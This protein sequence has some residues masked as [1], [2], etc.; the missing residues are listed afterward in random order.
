MRKR[1]KS[2]RST[3]VQDLKDKLCQNEELRSLEEG[4]SRLREEYLEKAT[5]K[6]VTGTGC[7]GF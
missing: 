5:S 7:G 4:L 6:T 1:G 3:E 2:G